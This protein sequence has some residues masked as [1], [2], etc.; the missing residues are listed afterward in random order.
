MGIEQLV[1]AYKGNP[2]PLQEKVQKAQQGQAPGAIPPDLEEAIALQKI[3]ELR[4]SAQGQQAIQAGGA[5]PSIVEK[6]RQ[7]LAADQRQQA[8]PPQMPQGGQPP[9]A[10]QGQPQ[11]GQPP[12][13]PQ[14]P[15]GQ[16]PVMAARGGSIAELMSNLGRH[17]AGGGIVAFSGE[18]GSDVKDE[19][20]L[21]P[22]EAREILRRMIQ[23]TDM[24]PESMAV[25]DMDTTSIPGFVAGNRFQQEMDKAT[26]KREP[27]TPQQ[28][29][30]NVKAVAPERPPAE[31]YSGPQQVTQR[32]LAE[33]YV[34]KRQRQREEDAK[35]PE[36]EM[37]KL[38]KQPFQAAG[39]GITSLLKSLYGQQMPGEMPEQAGAD[40]NEGQAIMQAARNREAAQ[41]N[42]PVAIGTEAQRSLPSIS[43]KGL[44]AAVAAMTGQ[45]GA[46][47][48]SGS[49]RVSGGA[50]TGVDK[51]SMPA[52]LAGLPSTG[53]GRDYERR[54]LA[55]NQKFDPEAY[56]QKFLAE[57]GKKDTSIYDEMA[58]ELKAR[59]ERLNNP[60][61]G[62]ESF[63]EYLGQIAESGGGRDWTESGS[64]GASRLAAL[65]KERQTKQDELVDKILDLGA[66]KKE[67]EYS[68]RLGLF[69][70]T[71]TEKERIGTE[72]R[73]LAK[74]LGLSEDKE[75]ELRQ[76]M[77]IEIM[78]IKANKE[79]AGMPGAEQ[80]FFNEMASSWLAQ[81]ENK[82]KTKFD[83]YAAFKLAGSPSAGGKGIM[84][85]DQAAD[86]VRKN[87]EYGAPLRTQYMD[88]ATQALKKAGISS[89][90][91]TQIMDYLVER[92]LGKA[93][94][95]TAPSATVPTAGT[96]MNGYKFKGGDPGDKNNWE[97]V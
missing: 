76:S 40:Q 68:E 91:A 41:D 55:E 48:A 59:K 23:R 36:D 4:N 85:R 46:S 69:N 6:L 51:G 5:Q 94:A 9:Q 44:P 30:S 83:A 61:P 35:K 13:P 11:M 7:M 53:V 19:K 42:R 18:D 50:S 37:L 62:F 67:A 92:E 88:E 32:E 95:T 75:A 12:Q 97:K 39:R 47:G 8:Q 86:N 31:P 28:M 93:N 64:K 2:A 58:A 73:E 96:V 45:G 21:T 81:P 49:G 25:T 72:S 65:R 15:Q 17:Y 24:R 87:I 57:V 33:A 1:E 54:M 80:K 79:I 63:M 77:A 16:P 89:P 27:M 71:K 38:V 14:P 56:K 3:T 82:G 60:Q 10:P 90:S 22:E 43:G 70:L 26:G 66:K 78:K 52:G 84:T 74:S 29:E 34:Q 20:E